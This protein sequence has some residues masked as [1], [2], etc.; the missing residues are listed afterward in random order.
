MQDEDQRLGDLLT[1]L[2][3]VS[4]ALRA[5]AEQHRDQ[6][7]L[8]SRLHNLARDAESIGLTADGCAPNSIDELELA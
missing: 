8:S 6:V 7:E 4:A 3:G 2:S 5:Y 1:F